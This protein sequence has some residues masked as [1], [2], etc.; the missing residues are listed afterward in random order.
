MST[1]ATM[2]P[3]ISTNSVGPA[4]IAHL[5]RMWLKIRL[6]ALGRLDGEYRHGVGGLDERLFEHFDIDGPAFVTFVETSHPD[7]LVAERYFLDHA[8]NVSPASI[9]SF[10]ELIRAMEFPDPARAKLFRDR[11]GIAD[12]SVCRVIELNDLDDWYGM[13]EALLG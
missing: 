2:V 10:N 6:A 8:K 7:Y 9:A 3:L 12:E 1:N 11:V 5:P 4:G 13:H